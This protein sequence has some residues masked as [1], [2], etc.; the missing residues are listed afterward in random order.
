MLLPN[1]IKII[2]SPYKGFLKSND[3]WKFLENEKQCLH[4]YMITFI[5]KIKN[6]G[7]NNE[8]SIFEE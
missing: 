4:I 1:I 7:H 2:I 6:N 5:L 8:K 3:V